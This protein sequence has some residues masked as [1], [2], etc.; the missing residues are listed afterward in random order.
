MIDKKSWKEFQNSGLLWWINMILHTFGW[1]IV[2]EQDKETKE[3]IQA[4]PARVSFRGFD[5][6]S[7]SKGY[8]NVSQYMKDNADTLLD[9]S[10][11]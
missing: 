10:K 9:E 8:I 2:I 11:E 5:N 6:S 7:N 3:I 4:Y 1:A